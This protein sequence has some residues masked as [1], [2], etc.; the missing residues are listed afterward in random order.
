MNPDNSTPKPNSLM[1]R[2][3]IIPPQSIVQLFPLFPRIVK[4]QGSTVKGMFCIGRMSPFRFTIRNYDVPSSDPTG[5]SRI[6]ISSGGKDLCTFYPREAS[7]PR[8][9]SKTRLMKAFLLALKAAEGKITGIAINDP[10][11][12]PLPEDLRSRSGLL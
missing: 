6:T 2:S 5:G 12:F 4:I 10:V 8:K 11:P 9:A 7:L 3:L 1:Q